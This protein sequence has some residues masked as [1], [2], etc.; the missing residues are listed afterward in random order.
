MKRHYQYTHPEMIQQ[1]GS[2]ATSLIKTYSHSLP[3][4]PLLSC[5]VQG[6]EGTHSQVHGHMAMCNPLPTNKRRRPPAGSY[7][8]EPQQARLTDYFSK[9][10]GKAGGRD[11]AAEARSQSG[12][13]LSA[14]GAHHVGISVLDCKGVQQKSQAGSQPPMDTR[15]TAT[16]GSDGPGSF[17][18]AGQSYSI[19]MPGPGQGYTSQGA[20]MA[21]PHGGVEV[22]EMERAAEGPGGG[23]QSSAID[24]HGGGHSHPEALP[25]PRSRRRAPV[26]LHEEASAHQ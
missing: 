11:Q 10:S 26:P 13:I 17:H 12:S 8:Q 22:S 14:G 25:D 1:L 23:H 7:R 15:A 9:A 20:R 16:E 19:R 6:L 24:R 4:V 5:S 2:K 21:R 18:G 3:H